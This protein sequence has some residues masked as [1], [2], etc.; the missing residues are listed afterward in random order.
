MDT[1]K[2]MINFGQLLSITA[3]IKEDITSQYYNETILPVMQKIANH[4]EIIIR[5]S[6]TEPFVIGKEIVL[7]F[8]APMFTILCDHQYYDGK[9][10]SNLCH[11]VNTYMETNTLMTPIKTMYYK[12]SFMKKCFKGI[13]SN[14]INNK[15][16]GKRESTLICSFEYPIKASNIIEFI[17]NREKKPILYIRGSKSDLVEQGNTFNIYIIRENQTLKEALSREQVVKKQNYPE[18]LINRNYVIVNLYPHFHIPFF[19][20]KMVIKKYTPVHIINKLMGLIE[21]STYILMPKSINNT[22]DL[23]QDRTIIH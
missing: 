6:K 17:Q 1:V 20:E 3:I 7:Y 21:S 14:A 10:I 13:S 5:N 2:K 4:N 23:Y 19:C 8:H 12:E 15:L 22:C 16:L 9:V 11:Q 18:F